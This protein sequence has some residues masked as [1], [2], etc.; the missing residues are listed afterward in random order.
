M[1]FLR[2]AVFLCGAGVLLAGALTVPARSQTAGP[3]ISAPQSGQV[4]QGLVTITGT[5]QVDGFASAAIDFSYTGDPTGTW[6]RIASSDQAVTEGT[7]AAWDTT[8]I[9]DAVYDLRL[10]VTLADGTTADSLVTALRV[11]NYTPVETPTPTATAV[12]TQTTPT[13]TPTLSPTPYP[14]PTELPAN[15]VALTTGDVSASIGIGIAAG[16]FFLGLLGFYLWLR[17]R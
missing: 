10:R 2:R 7:L 14:T 3:A 6:F 4:L 15:P 5:T 12:V 13:S 9:T 11:R 16:V 1:H 17:R 8:T